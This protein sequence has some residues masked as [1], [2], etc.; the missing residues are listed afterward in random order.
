MYQPKAGARHHDQNNIIISGIKVN[1]GIRKSVD[2]HK[3]GA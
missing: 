2:F 3:K 1:Q